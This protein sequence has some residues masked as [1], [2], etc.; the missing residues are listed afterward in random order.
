MVDFTGIYGIEIGRIYIIKNKINN[1]VYIGKT[2]HLTKSRWNQ[3]INDLNKNKHCNS[4][5]QR[6]WNLYGKEFFDFSLLE[7]VRHE[8]INDYENKWIK[9]YKD[10]C[11]NIVGGK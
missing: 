4:G 5:L 7:C 8:L 6:D 1:K 10:N 2:I 9:A 3:H 11:Y